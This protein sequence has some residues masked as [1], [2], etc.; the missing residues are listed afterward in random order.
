M[1]ITTCRMYSKCPKTRTRRPALAATS[2]P[3]PVPSEKVDMTEIAAAGV[4]LLACPAACWTEQLL[5]SCSSSA[6]P[7][8][9]RSARSLSPTSMIITENLEKRLQVGTSRTLEVQSKWR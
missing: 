2:D 9:M 7:T 3:T 6:F 1:N 5:D 4:T 8:K